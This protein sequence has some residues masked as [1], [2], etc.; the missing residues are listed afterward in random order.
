MPTG[1]WNK[2]SLHH[3]DQISC[4]GDEFPSLGSHFVENGF[5]RSCKC[6]TSGGRDHSEIDNPVLLR[7]RIDNDRYGSL[8]SLDHRCFGNDCTKDDDSEDDGD[9]FYWS[10]HGGLM[11][12]R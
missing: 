10:I 4:G 6:S 12:D 1:F 5:Q 7:C 8:L 2:S 11:M 9:E 3:D